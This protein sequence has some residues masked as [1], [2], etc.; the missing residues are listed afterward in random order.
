MRSSSGL[1]LS[2][3]LATV[4]IGFALSNCG[5]PNLDVNLRSHA[6]VEKE[7]GDSLG[8]S[9]GGLPLRG[10]SLAGG[11]FSPNSLP[12]TFN[13][14]YTYPTHAEVDYFSAKAMT[15][16]RI[17]F[18][19]ERLQ[20]QAK[21]GLD[22]AELGRLDDIVNYATGKGVNVLLDPHNYAR[23]YNQLIG[24]S[25][26]PN[27]AFADFWSRL[28]AHYGSNSHVIFGLMNEP[29]DIAT[30]Q[31]ESAA[32]AAINAIRATKATNL[33]LVPGNGWTGAHSWSDNYY[34][35]PSSVV[36]LK[37]TD[38]GNNY[39]FEVHQYLDSDNSGT[40]TSC[41][42]ATYGSAAMANFTAWLRANGKRGFLGEF[43]GANN[44]TCLA[45]INDQITYLESNSDV[46]LGWAWWAAGPWWGSYMYSIESTNTGNA[47][48]MSLLSEHL[49]KVVGPSPSPA[50]NP[51]TGPNGYPYCTNGSDTGGGY[52]W[53]TSVTDPRG[54][55]SCLVPP[56]P[57]P[58]PAPA[59][60][61]GGLP[62]LSIGV[63]GNAAFGIGNY[64]SVLQTDKDNLY[65][66]AQAAGASAQELALVIS[67][68]MQETT[69]MLVNQRDA[70]KDG[71][72]SANISFLN[73]NYDMLVH[74]GYTSNDNGMS[75]N[76]P[77]Q[78]G[79]VV[80]YLL[81][82]FRTW[83]VQSTLNYIRGGYTAFQDGS[84]YDAA[85]YRNAIN[86]IY[87]QIAVDLSLETDGRRVEV[88][89]PG[90]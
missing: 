20:R 90:V 82:G 88:S 32:Q 41:V 39:A 89:V 51:K 10:V 49:Q 6:H 52:G 45:A 43:A 37:I 63:P 66:V 9:T 3:R 72:P 35:T 56:A 67:I 12:G 50:P 24:S 23:Y 13:S 61:P 77:N 21:Q 86:T 14:N 64:G 54:S 68:A 34:G 26:V 44:G 47:P 87:N 28:A 59:P 62:P 46:Y 79:T 73:L 31:W 40:H 22:G 17:P 7:S 57:T 5:Q 1:E 78:L 16:I 4:L 30:E 55:H 27:S 80:G 36:M 11:D 84:S 58:S 71:T 83:G 69:L 2:A 18:L 25:S 65:N 70:S 38:P 76:A 19:W 53:D 29:H 85:G 42:S 8:L 75:L 60:S 15:L 33:I 74:L 81:K 48:I